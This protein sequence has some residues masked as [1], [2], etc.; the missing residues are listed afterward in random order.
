[1]NKL[2]YC[3]NIK[4]KNKLKCTIEINGYDIQHV[5]NTDYFYWRNIYD[6]SNSSST[7]IINNLN[8]ITNGIFSS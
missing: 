1:M 5:I 2:L 7:N 8:E 3:N 6:D 4:N